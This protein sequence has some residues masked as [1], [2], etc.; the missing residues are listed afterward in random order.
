MANGDKIT[1]T[2]EALEVKHTN[3]GIDINIIKVNG[4]GY[5]YG[6]AMPP[7]NVGDTVEFIEEYKWNTSRVAYKT[8]TVPIQSL[9]GGVQTP[10]RG[11]SASHGFPIPLRD[12]QRSIIRQNALAHA[13]KVV[14]ETDPQAALRKGTSVVDNIISVARRFEEYAAGDIERKEAEARSEA[15]GLQTE[16]PGPDRAAQ[17]LPIDVFG[18]GS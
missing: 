14:I 2:V 13:T 8:L 9:K 3:R 17:D 1:G 12:K 6:K 5:E 16:V 11:G 18:D 7:C 10:S 4:V 15:K